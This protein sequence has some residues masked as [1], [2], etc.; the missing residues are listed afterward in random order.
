MLA[1]T[2]LAWA[3]LQLARFAVPP[4]L[5]EIRADLGLSLSE[6]GVALTVFQGV[7]AAF[8]Y[9]S[10][11]LSDNWG[12]ATLLAP[13]FIVLGI[14]CLLVGGAAGFGSLLVGLAVF[15]VG[16]GLYAIPSRALLSDLFVERR[17][18]ALGV[19][20]AGTDLGGVLASGV[21]NREPYAVG[22]SELAVVATLRRL[23]A[24]PRQRRSI[25]AFVCFY[26]MVNGVLNFLPEYLR[27]AKGFSAALAGGTYALLFVFGLAVKPVAG[28]LSDRFPR[29]RVAAG[30]MVL[31]AAAL[32]ALVVAGSSLA[33]GAAIV[34][35]AFGY[36]AQFPVID[37]ILLD[38]APSADAGADLGAARTLFLGVGSLGPAF[39]GVVADR[40][41][42]A[43]GFAALVGILVVAPVLLLADEW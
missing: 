12:R 7:Y 18:Q 41:D 16:K 33:V 30:G 9:P 3:A 23:L 4:L 28:A 13:S 6:A 40:F 26:F 37:A 43:V 35:F 39:V 25:A 36:K 29:R 34:V 21:W 5:P 27:V 17:G 8:Q 19:F 38:A 14:G 20:S 15:G 10:G 42:F 31:A 2:A 11:R 24:T 1:V 32:G 22:R